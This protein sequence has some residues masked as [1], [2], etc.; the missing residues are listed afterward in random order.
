MDSKALVVKSNRLVRASFRLTLLEQQLILF[1]IVQARSENKGLSEGD[2]VKIQ[3]SEFVKM[4]TAHDHKDIYADV[5]GAVERLWLR[6]CGWED[7]KPDGTVW[8]RRAR[9]LQSIAYQKG[10]GAIEL[11]FSSEIAP[12]ITRLE[13]NFTC[14]QIKNIAKLSNVHAIRFYELLKQHLAVGFKS[15]TL[16][17]IRK[18]LELDNQY[19]EYH[20]FKK[21]VIDVVVRQI[22]T[23]TDLDVIAAPMKKKRAVTGIQFRIHTKPKAAPK[24]PAKSKSDSG[25]PARRNLMTFP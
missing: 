22:N 11:C 10:G 13:S 16:V 25:K 3:L 6:E 20:D 1:S 19:A 12:L 23:H 7:V 9:W 15:Y 17:E 2:D 5:K 4:F 21:R 18:F 24:V 14:Y 8:L